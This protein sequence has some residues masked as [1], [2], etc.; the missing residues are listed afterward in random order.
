[1]KNAAKKWYNY[2]IIIGITGILFGCAYTPYHAS[3]GE[4]WPAR[5]VCYFMIFSGIVVGLCGFIAQDIYKGVIRHKINDW[6][7]KLDEKYEHKAWAIFFPMLMSGAL[8]FAVGVIASF[9][10]K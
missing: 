10:V 7:N 6:T 4:S 9:F 5:Y 1:M 2:L 3:N 8:A